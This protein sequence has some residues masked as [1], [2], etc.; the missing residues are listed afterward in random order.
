MCQVVAYRRLKT[1]ENSTTVSRNSGPGR[2]REVVAR[3]GSTVKP[4]KMRTFTCKSDICFDFMQVGIGQFFVFI[5]TAYLGNG[6]SKGKWVGGIHQKS[7][8]N[9]MSFQ[10]HLHILVPALEYN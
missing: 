7:L 3:E 2:L 8:I 4:L 1:I 5:S 9:K 6:A 10:I